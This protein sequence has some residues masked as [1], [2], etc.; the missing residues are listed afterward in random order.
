MYK[1]GVPVVALKS[2][3]VWIHT[4]RDLP[5]ATSAALLDPVVGMYRDI[6]NRLLSLPPT[7]VRQA[8]AIGRLAAQHSPDL[9]L[10]LGVVSC[11]AYS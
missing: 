7:L 3:F 10:A 11:E 4:A 9:P 1:A 6:A 2:T 5:D 8:N